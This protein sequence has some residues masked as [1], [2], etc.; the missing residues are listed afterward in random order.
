MKKRILFLVGA[1]IVIVL[2]W[3]I[4]Q[5]NLPETQALLKLYGPPEY[6]KVDMSQSWKGQVRPVEVGGRQFNI[7]RAYIDGALDKGLVQDG[8]N[9]KYV[10]PDYQ[11]LLSLKNKEEY[12]KEFNAG[13]I[14]F[15]LIEPQ[16]RY[17]WGI[18]KSAS[19]LLDSYSEGKHVGVENDLDRYDGYRRNVDKLEFYDKFYLEKSDDGTVIGF[20]I[21]TAEWRVPAPGCNH[22]FIDEN[23]RYNIHYRIA[24]FP[25]WKKMK[26]DAIKFI[27][28]FEVKKSPQLSASGE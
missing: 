28:A 20:I 19:A 17:V 8:V 25:Q 4:Y 3:G 14:A 13:H 18:D 9:L 11:P 7:P 1:L 26:N 21:C 10:F 12:L 5:F 24:Y 27:N 6:T 23:V 2:A 16:S 15:M 22:Q